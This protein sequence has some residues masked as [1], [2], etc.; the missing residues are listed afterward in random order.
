M[1]QTKIMDLIPENLHERIIKEVQEILE[2]RQKQQEEKDNK[3]IATKEEIE[4]VI[5]NII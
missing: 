5:G 3:K 2:G 4:A 1:A